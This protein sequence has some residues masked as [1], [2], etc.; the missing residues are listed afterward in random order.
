MTEARLQS[1]D[2]GRFLHRKQQQ[3]EFRY[4]DRSQERLPLGRAAGRGCLGQ[5]AGCA[6]KS[7]SCAHVCAASH[8]NASFSKL[9]SEPSVDSHRLRPGWQA[10]LGVR[11]LRPLAGLKASLFWLNLVPFQFSHLYRVSDG[12]PYLGGLF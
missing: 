8:I 4:V 5:D 2:F 9:R 12:G 6:G 11:F 3:A 7:P 10:G 1:T